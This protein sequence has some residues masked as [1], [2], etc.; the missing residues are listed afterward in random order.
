MFRGACGIANL[1]NVDLESS[2][3]VLILS[4]VDLDESTIQILDDVATEDIPG[5]QVNSVGNNWTGDIV[6][7]DYQRPMILNFESTTFTGAIRT[8][9][10]AHWNSLFADYAGVNYVQS[11]DSGLFVNADDPADTGS[12]YRVVDPNAIY[13][14]LC[15]FEDY[16]AERGTHLSLDADSVWNV[17]GESN[18]DELSVDAGGVI[19]GIVTVDGV[20]TDVSAGGHWTGD[21]VITSAAGSGEPSGSASGEASGSA[22]APGTANGIVPGTYSDGESELVIADDMTFV[23]TTLGENMEG[24]GFSLTVTG[25]VED[26]EF[27]ITGLF[28]GDLDLMDLATDAQIADN[29]AAIQSAYNG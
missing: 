28:D 21:I 11:P 5:C 2:T 13:G 9:D 14:W 1:E 18:I 26:G 17:T 23:M 12:N 20:E 22:E 15:A 27:V 24:A 16:A 7:E 25:V 6:N 29:Y 3:G 19:N 4:C 10:N 8:Y